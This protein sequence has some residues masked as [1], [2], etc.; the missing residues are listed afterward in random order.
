[1]STSY[2]TNFSS[3]ERFWSVSKRYPKAKTSSHEQS[4]D[5][6]WILFTPQMFCREN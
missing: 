4:N 6:S 5:Y 3:S 2:F 1:M